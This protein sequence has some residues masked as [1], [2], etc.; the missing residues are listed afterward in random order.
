MNGVPSISHLPI[1]QQ[2]YIKLIMYDGNT[3]QSQQVFQ[4]NN[5]RAILGARPEQYNIQNKTVIIHCGK[6]GIVRRLEGLLG[7]YSF[8]QNNKP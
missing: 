6:D 8:R 1:G 3:I 5:S 7:D 4:I 2:T